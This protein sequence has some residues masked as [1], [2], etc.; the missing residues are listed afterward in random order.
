MIINRTNGITPPSTA[1]ACSFSLVP[2]VTRCTLP[3]SQEA[4]QEAAGG[5]ETAAKVE[6]LVMAYNDIQD[7]LYEI[8]KSWKNNLIFY[9]IP[10]WIETLGAWI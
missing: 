10:V 4:A 7:R 3:S 5:Q 9:G 6:G 8:D 2:A 1:W